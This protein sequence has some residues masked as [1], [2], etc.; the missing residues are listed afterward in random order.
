MIIYLR[1]VSDIGGK[2]CY[3][4]DS[5]IRMVKLW[6]AEMSKCRNVEMSKWCNGDMLKCW[7]NS[8][9]LKV[10][11]L[12]LLLLQQLYTNKKIQTDTLREQ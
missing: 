2:E 9:V 4:D 3:K 6:N 7:N 11:L 1:E 5:V 8:Y 12:L 10:L